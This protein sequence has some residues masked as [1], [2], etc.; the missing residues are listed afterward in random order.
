MTEGERT[1]SES[2]FDFGFKIELDEAR[3][4]FTKEE[5]FEDF[6]FT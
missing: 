5:G 2:G 3:K 4:T 6:G 1:H